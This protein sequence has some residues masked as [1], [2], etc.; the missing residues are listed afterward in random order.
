MQRRKGAPSTSNHTPAYVHLTTM[1]PL[2]ARMHCALVAYQYQSWSMS[3]WLTQH[4][5]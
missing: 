5:H 4:V 3:I 1:H 2:T